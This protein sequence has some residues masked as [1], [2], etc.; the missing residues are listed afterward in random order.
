M[1]DARASAIAPATPV[2]LANLVS[3]AEGSIVSRAIVQKPIAS[4][5][6]FA[7][8]AGQSLSEHTTAYDAYVEVLDGEVDLVIGGQ[9][10]VARAGETVLMPAGVPHAV[11]AR[12]RFKM[13][14]TMVRA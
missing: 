4:V 2:R 7:F 13:T 11:T 3:Y 1:P 10:V 12:Q 5:T 14:L 8:D 6:L 9:A